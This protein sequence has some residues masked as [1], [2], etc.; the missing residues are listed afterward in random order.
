MVVHVPASSSRRDNFVSIISSSQLSA[1]GQTTV[2]TRARLLQ[3]VTEVSELA[4]TQKPILIA[5][6][7]YHQAIR[8]STD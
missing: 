3:A 2:C 8:G 7:V 6:G 5:L 4:L 1:F